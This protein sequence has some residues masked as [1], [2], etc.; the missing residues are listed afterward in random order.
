MKGVDSHGSCKNHCENRII[1][2]ADMPYNDTTGGYVLHMAVSNSISYPVGNHL[3][4]GS[5]GLWIRTG[6]RHRSGQDACGRVYTLYPAC[7]FRLGSSVAG[8]T[9]NQTDGRLKRWN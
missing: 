5:P 9:Q 1:A 6:D 2:S 8:N 3:Y 4:H 7:A